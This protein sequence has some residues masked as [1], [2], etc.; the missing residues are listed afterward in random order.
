MTFPIWKLKASGD[1]DLWAT[2]DNRVY[3]CALNLIQTFCSHFGGE[4]T[5]RG[6]GREPTRWG[7]GRETLTL[8]CHIRN[9]IQPITYVILGAQK[10]HKSFLRPNLS[11]IDEK[12]E[13]R[14]NEFLFAQAY[15]VNKLQSLIW[16]HIDLTP[17]PSF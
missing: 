5:R 9:L 8:Q 11:F 6:W 15:R 3:L 13:V 12:T 2:K 4:P 1:E 10:A 16:K 7:W 17:K 14:K